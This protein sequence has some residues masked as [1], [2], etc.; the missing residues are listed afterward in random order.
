MDSSSSKPPEGP[1]D[2]TLGNV[3]SGWEDAM[4]DIFESGSGASAPSA[5]AAAAALPSPMEEGEAATTTAT[6]T[7]TPEEEGD[8]L[9]DIFCTGASPT[10]VA[11]VE[12]NTTFD[13]FDDQPPALSPSLAP[14]SP[15]PTAVAAVET[16]TTFDFFD[17]QPPALSPNLAPL[18]PAQFSIFD[19]EPDLQL[20]PTSFEA[21]V[22]S[23][24]DLN[25]APQPPPEMEL[26]EDPWAP[27]VSESTESEAP[28][29]EAIDILSSQPPSLRKETPVEESIPLVPEPVVSFPVE[30][31][32]P[33]ESKPLAPE[34]V[35][36]VPVEKT[37]PI[38]SKSLVPES[39]APIRVEKIKEPVMSAPM[40]ME[41]KPVVPE[42]VAP[43]PIDKTKEP[44][45]VAIA[46]S[47][48]PAIIKSVTTPLDEK[49]EP[50]SS[51][52]G[53]EQPKPS[54]I[55]VDAVPSD[56]VPETTP[57]DIMESAPYIEPEKAPSMDEATANDD[58]EKEDKFDMDDNHN[59]APH[60]P[61]DAH[62]KLSV[63]SD[64]D[65]SDYVTQ[66]TQDKP[67]MDDLDDIL[68]PMKDDDPSL[69]ERLDN[70]ASTTPK[71][72]SNDKSVDVLYTILSEESSKP[73]YEKKV[74]LE[75]ASL[76]E[77][78][79]STAPKTVEP[80]VPVTTTPGPPLAE[81]QQT[82]QP[83]PVPMPSSP[84]PAAAPP[85][86]PVEEQP[87]GEKPLN[88]IVA[89]L[90]NFVPM[91]GTG[92][93]QP[94]LTPAV[95]TQK[96]PP[97]YPAPSSSTVGDASFRTSP[98]GTAVSVLSGSG[99]FWSAGPLSKSIFSEGMPDNDNQAATRMA[100]RKQAPAPI[101][102]LTNQEESFDNEP[103]QGGRLWEAAQLEATIIEARPTSPEASRFAESI[104]A[105]TRSRADPNAVVSNSASLDRAGT[106]AMNVTPSRIYNTHISYTLL[107]PILTY[108]LVAVSSII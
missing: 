72:P 54:V 51:I 56:E 103:M 90:D 73:D 20:S 53:D 86:P 23:S 83:P 89:S 68:G 4:A 67:N 32:A 60:I 6:A 46:P 35:A 55:D 2:E 63:R 3:G 97:I 64:G 61:S 30:Q 34:P 25:S 26:S 71:S 81:M 1:I 17:D 70:S 92:L 57:F 9:D 95:V 36:H 82:K 101:S 37:V 41:S 19:Q 33:M 88:R 16:T 62:S 12:T 39:A 104:M 40:A 91:M 31:T 21:P 15:T 47:E 28:M 48:S 99:S 45:I 59:H 84:A 94:V 13:F 29:D 107:K 50:K 77:V 38:E 98:S 66:F 10:A 69:L 74:L 22:L 44:V 105:R 78:E 5:A 93:P 79:G 7:A 80:F 49:V 87:P 65:L 102:T 76:T 11:A 8:L 106:L 24:T 43:V 52:D 108:F 85:A 75:E 14:L 18:S 100:A 42:P 96:P 58:D 27:L